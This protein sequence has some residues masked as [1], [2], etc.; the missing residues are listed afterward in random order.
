MSQHDEENGGRGYYTSNGETAP[1]SAR[2]E[3]AQYLYLV[4]T[5]YYIFSI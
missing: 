4:Y 5:V 3:S 2:A 1:I